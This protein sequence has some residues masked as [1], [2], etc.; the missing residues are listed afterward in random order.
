[1]KYTEAYQAAMNKIAVELMSDGDL[2]EQYGHKL[3][4]MYTV[5]EVL[6]ISEKGEK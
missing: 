1:M 3:R 2:G 5:G 4:S 6:E